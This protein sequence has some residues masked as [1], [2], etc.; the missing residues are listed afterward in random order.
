MLL[1]HY[2]K[3][4]IYITGSSICYAHWRFQIPNVTYVTYDSNN[5]RKKKCHECHS[6]CRSKQFQINRKL[7][8]V[9]RGTLAGILF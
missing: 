8:T 3:V 7:K 9:F 6:K 1:N 2:F 4:I 5:N